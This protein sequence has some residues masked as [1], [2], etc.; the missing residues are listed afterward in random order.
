MKEFLQLPEDVASRE[1]AAF[2]MKDIVAK[3]QALNNDISFSLLSNQ[4]I[5]AYRM[6]Q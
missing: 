6:A 3:A 2:L 1:F 4:L 5:L